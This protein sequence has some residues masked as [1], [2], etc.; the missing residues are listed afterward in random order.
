M[1]SPATPSRP[2][3]LRSD[4]RPQTTCS[5]A[6]RW[7]TTSGRTDGP[8]TA[9]ATPAVAAWPDVKPDDAV[10]IH[11]TSGTTG[12]P[13]GCVL[14]H[15]SWAVVATAS[16]AVLPRTPGESSPT[17]R[18]FYL[19]APLELSM[20]LLVG[21]EQY[22]AEKVSLSQF[23]GWLADL[24]IDYAEVWEILGDRIIDPDAE[25]RLRQRSTPLM[26]S[27]FGLPGSQ[28]AAL[29]ERLNADIR[30]MFGMTE[31]GLATYAP[32]DDHTLIGSGSCGRA[33]S[34]PGDTH[35]RSRHVA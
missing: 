8:R 23:T 34:L 15:R 33:G 9:S 28:Q 14:T 19:D 24:D 1:S 18:Y 35:C 30:E 27:T 3:W 25:H 4:S 10:G 2:R 31:V 5:P 21:A 17:R 16:A 6:I 32:Y 20:A 7:P 13:K 11:Y 26:L 12:L 22:V 29:Q